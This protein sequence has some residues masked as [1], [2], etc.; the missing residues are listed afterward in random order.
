VPEE[1]GFD[2]CH[3]I[4]FLGKFISMPLCVF[5]LKCSVEKEKKSKDIG[6]KIKNLYT[7]A[8]QG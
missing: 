3:G 1:P 6:P 5:D 7:G 4:S 2:S 8:R